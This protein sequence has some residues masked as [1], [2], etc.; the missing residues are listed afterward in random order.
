M[1]TNKKDWYKV[2]G[3]LHL[4]NKLSP[5][6]RKKVA[7]YVQDSKKI[8][9]HAF[10]PLIYKTISQRRF[11]VVG[12]TTNGKPIRKHKKKTDR[13]LT[14]STKKVRPIH[15]ASHLDAQIYSYYAKEIL[16][17]KYEKHLAAIKGLSK[18]VTAYR[19]IAKPDGKGNKCNIDIAAD[20][21][22]EIKKRG[23]CIAIA[24]DIKS[25]FTTLDHQILKK[26]WARVLG[27]DRLPSDHY[28]IF[29]SITR[30]RYIN[31]SDFRY[32]KNAFD[33]QHL[34]EIRK[35]G[36]NAYIKDFKEFKELIRTKEIFVRKNQYKND[37]APRRLIG[38][39]Q[40]LPISAILANI[41]MTDFDELMLNEL[42]NKHG[43]YYRRYSDD[44]VIVCNLKQK[45]YVRK[46]IDK[47]IESPIVK[48]KTAEEKTE[49]SHFQFK[50]IGN[51]RRLQVYRERPDGKLDF[52]IPFVYLGFE[53]YG[54]Q[55]L[56]KSANVSRF[57]RQMKEA[58]K[59]QSKRAD[60]RIEKQAV[61]RKI[62]YK[63]KL[64]RHF[65]HKGKISRELERKR[66]ILLQD[67]WGVWRHKTKNE[68][69]LFRGNIFRYVQKSA[70][71][72]NAPEINKQYRNHWKVLRE[73]ITKHGFENNS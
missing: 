68:P 3:Y 35:N 9:H 53:F 28:N 39:P 44:I 23:E 12:Y 62:I 14:E 17:P 61:D 15:Y 71:I 6:K 65:T 69:Y 4:D 24:I 36:I 72:H 34:S 7:A 29:K 21:F 70:E 26:Q 13:G 22:S 54:Y 63:T 30:Y 56:I 50:K 19:K 59:K 57:Y 51:N 1:Q 31:L 8:A 33:E 52:N 64:Y 37:E 66:S 20:A 5:G 42:V 47:N 58:I 38:I 11:K 48:L 49:I 41:Y 25:F 55:T 2:K 73:T 67:E 16:L 27:S 18:C 45:N 32:K 60:R 10:L 43:I 40:G 46:F